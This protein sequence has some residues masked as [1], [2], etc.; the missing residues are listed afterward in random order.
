MAVLLADAPLEGVTEVNVT[1]DRVDAH[2]D[3]QWITIVEPNQTY[4][5]LDLVTESTSLG[6]GVLPAGTYTQVRFFVSEVTIVD[7]DGT[8]EL[9]IPS[10]VQTGIKVNLDTTI[11]EG[12]LVTILLDFNAQESF[13]KAGASGMYLMTPVVKGV[14]VSLAGTISGSASIEGSPVQGVQ[15][16]A[17]Y[18]AG[19][20]YEQGTIVNTTATV[21]AGVFKVWALLPGTYTLKFTYTN[22]DTLEEFSAEVADVVVTAEND[23]AVGDVALT[24]VG[25]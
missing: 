14:V 10:G 18:Q 20:G 9:T 1:I 7:A 11:E 21:E 23:T 2:K 5:L 3:G 8:H 24:P 25:P 12:S 16:E 19:Q 17:T 4:N 22:P 15:V 6:A 13:I